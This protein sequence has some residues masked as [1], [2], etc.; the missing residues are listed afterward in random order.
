MLTNT[1]RLSPPVVECGVFDYPDDPVGQ[2][3]ALGVPLQAFDAAEI[4]LEF[5][6]IRLGNTVMLGAMS[7][8]L[9][10]PA[11]VLRDAV[12]ARFTHKKPGLLEMNLRAFDAGRER[13][14][15]LIGK[16]PVAA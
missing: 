7:D 4:A 8:H 5:G 15:A 12:A 14:A 2:L 10:F 11:S 1:S 6:D 13:A 3:R 9:P 16:R